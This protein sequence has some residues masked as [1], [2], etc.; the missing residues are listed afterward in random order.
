MTTV[1]IAI[2]SGGL[3]MLLISLP[4][5]YRKIPMNHFYG[6]RIRASFESDQRWYDI[7]AYGGRQM[8]AWSWLI[9]ATGL[10]G[11]FVPREH[12]LTYAWASIPVTLAAV[13]IPT[14]Q[15]F[16]WSRK[17]DA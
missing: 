3:V 1:A 5:I 16:R 15:I 6:I 11:F 2:L 14:I 13:L 7:N 12:F 10:L 9:I 4:L 17:H 8:A